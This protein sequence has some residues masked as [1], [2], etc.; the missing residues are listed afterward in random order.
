MYKARGVLASC[1]AN[2][3]PLLELTLHPRKD[4]GAILVALIVYRHRALDHAGTACVTKEVRNIQVNVS[5]V[6]LVA[7]HR[8]FGIVW[9]A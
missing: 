8:I 9:V 4:H 1:S 3:P 2:I 6:S 7:L 5:E